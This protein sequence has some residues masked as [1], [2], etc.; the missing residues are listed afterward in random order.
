MSTREHQPPFA[1]LYFDSC[2]LIQNR[3]PDPAVNLETVLEIAKRL[4]VSCFI[5]EP[6]L[7]E[8]RENWLEAIRASTEKLSNAAKAYERAARVVEAVATV[9]HEKFD[10]LRARYEERVN[11]AIEKNCV[12]VVPCTVR[13]SR[14]FFHLAVN[15]VRPFVEARNERGRSGAGRGFQDAV[16]LSSVLEHAASN[17]FKHAAFITSDSGFENFEVQKFFPETAHIQLDVCSLDKVYSKMVAF[18]W[19]VDVEQPWQLEQDNALIAA[20][21]N[22]EILRRFVEANIYP[23]LFPEG[24]GIESVISVDSIDVMYVQT[25]V[26]PPRAPDRE[27]K[28]AVAISAQC[29]VVRSATTHSYPVLLSQTL[30]REAGK[31]SSVETTWLWRGGIEVNSTIRNNDF[32]SFAPAGLVSAQELGSGKWF[33]S[34]S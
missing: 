18:W 32:I 7:Y 15:Y 4:K 16:I 28:M 12:I 8:V 24:S 9:Q 19:N 20:K 22:K 25:P 10:T 27:V 23:G 17:H 1:A 5:P 13:P 33:K 30:F 26:P 3:W 14:D 21:Q 11:S 6:V 34:N 31:A 2:E 29:R